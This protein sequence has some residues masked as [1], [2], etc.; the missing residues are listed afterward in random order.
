MILSNPMH[1]YEVRPGR[2]AIAVT[3]GCYL[4]LSGCTVTGNI[5]VHDITTGFDL[6]SGPA[7]TKG[8]VL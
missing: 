2:E 7:G 1:H 8:R 6:G 4:T 5:D 3:K